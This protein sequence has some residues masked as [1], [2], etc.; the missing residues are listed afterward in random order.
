MKTWGDDFFRLTSVNFSPVYPSLGSILGTTHQSIL[1]K[2]LQIFWLTVWTT[3]L[4]R[5]CRRELVPPMA[6]INLKYKSLEHQ[7]FQEP[8]ETDYKKCCPVPNNSRVPYKKVFLQCLCNRGDC[9]HS[10]FCHHSWDMTL[11]PDHIHFKRCSTACH[12]EKLLILQLKSNQDWSSLL[13]Y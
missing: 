13:T 7:V 10:F 5:S 6:G 4:F 3:R 1:H 9:S 8:A 11:C 12:S 2:F